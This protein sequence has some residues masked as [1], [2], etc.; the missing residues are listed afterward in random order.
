MSTLS[1]FR[2]DG[3]LARCAARAKIGSL[4]LGPLVLTI[5]GAVPVV[6]VLIAWRDG[7]PPAAVGFPAL[8]WLVV[9]AGTAGA[10]ADAGRLAWTVP[11]LLRVIEYGVLIRITLLAEPDA[12]PACFAVLGVLAFHHYDTVYRLRSQGAAP[13]AWTRTAT[14]GWDGRLLGAYALGVAGGF[15]AGMVAAAVVL[16]LAFGAES[17]VSWIRFA[18][19]SA[20]TVYDDHDLEAG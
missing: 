12:M 10:S 17:V 11:P 7:L 15:E 20:R 3:P 1:V 2:D 4:P 13:P 9:V 18:G 14:G 5:A 16:A 8:A 19:A 6:A